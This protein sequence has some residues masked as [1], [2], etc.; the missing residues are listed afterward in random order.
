MSF[1]INKRDFY[2]KHCSTTGHKTSD[3]RKNDQSEMARFTSA[4]EKIVNVK[5]KRNNFNQQSNANHNFSNKNDS[6]QNNWRKNG[7]QMT[8]NS[9]IMPNGGQKS[10][11]FVQENQGEM[12]NQKDIEHDTSHESDSSE[13]SD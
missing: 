8:N 5:P 12:Q 13:N 10:I 4:L 6:N 7:N 3:C 9:G 2:C 1:E 11:H